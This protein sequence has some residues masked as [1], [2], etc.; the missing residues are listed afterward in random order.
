MNLHLGS[1][2]SIY[3]ED[4]DSE[5]NKTG[6]PIVIQ[7]SHYY[8]FGGKLQGISP[9]IEEPE[10]T[11]QYN[12]KELTDEFGLNWT[13]YGARWLDVEL[14]RWWSVDP[15]AEKYYGWS[16]YNY[17]TGNPLLF[18]DPNGMEVIFAGDS[19]REL[20]NQYKGKINNKVSQYDRK[21]QRLKEQGKDKKASK[22]EAKRSRNIYVQIQGELQDIEASKDVF[23]IKMGANVS[24][25]DGG[26]NIAFNSGE[27]DVNLNTHGEFSDIQK[28]S[29][30]LLHAY[31][32]LKGD[33]DLRNDGRGGMLYDQTDE[34]AAFNRQ[35]LFYENRTGGGSS[36]DDVVSFVKAQYPGVSQVR[37][38]YQ[39]LSPKVK[40]QY[41][42][43]IRDYKNKG[44]YPKYMIGGWQNM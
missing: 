15:L 27:I 4:T 23:R 24:K 13:D 10:V 21:T 12:G 11:Y 26:G 2:R 16:G 25:K 36:I 3:R 38:S 20:Y 37:R 43:Q 42:N 34:I 5:G 31:Q 1:P 39:N 9:R 22:R 17:V 32:Y 18:I 14:G 19:E 41:L 6:D 44:A 29:H 7:E 8:P 33:I 35:N 28:L 40:E 30:E